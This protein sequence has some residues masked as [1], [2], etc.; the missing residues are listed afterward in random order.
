MLAD[1]EKRG[2]FSAAEATEILAILRALPIADGP[3]GIARVLGEVRQ[4]AVTYRSVRI[5]PGA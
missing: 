4:L 5:C 1:A 2:E 3:E